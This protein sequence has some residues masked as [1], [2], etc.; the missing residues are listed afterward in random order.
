MK[1]PV[2]VCIPRKSRTIG[3]VAERGNGSQFARE[4]VTSLPQARCQLAIEVICHAEI[5]APACVCVCVCVCARARTCYE[6]TQQT[7]ESW[8][9]QKQTK[10]YHTTVA[11]LISSRRISPCRSDIPVL[12]AIATSPSASSPCW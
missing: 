3:P 1:A 5:G 12:P 11:S 4:G 6:R 2:R 9:R 8:A 7:Y 10:R